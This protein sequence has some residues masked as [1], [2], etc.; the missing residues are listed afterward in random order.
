MGFAKHMAYKF[1]SGVL[2]TVAMPFLLLLYPIALLIE[3]VEEQRALWSIAEK[4][5]GTP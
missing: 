4:R 5:N 3:Y 2:W 1:A